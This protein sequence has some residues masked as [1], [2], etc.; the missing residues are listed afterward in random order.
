MNKRF[1]AYKLER[2]AKLKSTKPMDENKELDPVEEQA[3]EVLKEEGMSAA[4]KQAADDQ[5]NISKPE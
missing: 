3:A 4:D 2:S 1:Q 5:E